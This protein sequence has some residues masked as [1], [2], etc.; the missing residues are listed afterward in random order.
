MVW[1]EEVQ[2]A[3]IE[4][5][6][7]GQLVDALDSLSIA[8]L[9]DLPLFRYHMELALDSVEVVYYQN[10]DVYDLA[11]WLRRFAYKPDVRRALDQVKAGALESVLAECRGSEMADQNG[12]SLYLPDPYW[13]PYDTI[14]GDPGYGLDFTRDTHWDELLEAY[15]AST[16]S[17]HAP[18]TGRWSGP[19]PTGGFI[20]DRQR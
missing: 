9:K 5:D 17:N 6:R 7:V 11:A 20:P 12:L 13:V 3:A 15:F 10:A 8:Y 4:T 1:E 19:P 2:M 16:G 18:L 14:Y